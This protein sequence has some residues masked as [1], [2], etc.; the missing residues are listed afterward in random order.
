MRD[1]SPRVNSPS[2]RKPVISDE[3]FDSIWNL[4]RYSASLRSMMAWAIWLIP[5]CL[6][7]T[8]SAQ[9]EAP[10]GGIL[11]AFRRAIVQGSRPMGRAITPPGATLICTR[12]A[13]QVYTTNAYNNE[14]V[15]YLAIL[16][17][18]QNT[19]PDPITVF[20]KR[21]QLTVGMETFLRVQ[22]REELGSQPLLIDDAPIDVETLQ[23]QSE[24]VIPARS[25]A[26]VWLVYAKIPT[27]RE[28]PEVAIKIE[29]STGPIEVNLTQFENAAL[30]LQVERIGPQDC[31][32]IIRLTGELNALNASRF[33]AELSAVAEQGASRLVVAFQKGARLGDPRLSNWLVYGREQDSERFM[34]L[35]IWSGAIQDIAFVAIPGMAD[36][37]ED[38][39]A[40]SVDDGVLILSRRLVGQLDSQTLRQQLAA[41]HP[42]IRRAVL[43]SAGEMIAND[44][45]LLILPFLKAPDADARLAAIRALKSATA[46]AVI[47]PLE[48]TLLS[49]PSQEAFAALLS[50][51][52]SPI[53]TARS[54]AVA[55]IEDP[56]LQKKLGVMRILK[57]L[58]LSAQ[59][60]WHPWLRTLLTDKSANVR[61]Q[62]LQ[63]L[64]A[65]GVTDRAE[66]L[67]TALHDPQISVR[68]VAFDTLLVHRTDG[69]ESL[70][71][72]ETLRRSRQGTLD[73]RSRI[74]LRE[75]A[76]PG[77]LPIILK[78]IDQNPRENE[79]LVNLY[80]RIGGPAVSAEMI[81]RY[82]QFTP[83]TRSEILRQLYLGSDPAWIPLAIDGLEHEDD[84]H[85]ETCRNLLAEATDPTVLPKLAAAWKRSSDDRGQSICYTIG[86]IG[87]EAALQT[88]Q[89]MLKSAPVLRKKEIQLGITVW[90]GQS[91]S[92]EII[93]EAYSLSQSDKWEPAVELFT[94]AIE[95]GPNNPR[96]YSG[97]GHARLRL[98]QFDEAE[99]DFRRSMELDPDNHNSLSGLAICKAIRGQ[100]LDAIKMVHSNAML[101]QF[102]KEQIYLYNVACVYGRSLE[103]VLKEPASPQ[104]DARVH[105]FQ[106]Q[107]MRFLKSAVQ[108]GFDDG[109]LLAT[110]P[111]LNTLRELPAFQ[112]L[113]DRVP[114]TK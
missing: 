57:E 65:A 23:G 71:R 91:P 16:L 96:I 77:T 104:R 8:V 101:I 73:S 27:E 5:L 7:A 11:G 14:G 22:T 41:G 103:H 30:S 76:D 43:F 15:S 3:G 32:G 60:E 1:A 70:F 54:R 92:N 58:P 98:S 4:R 69:E 29:T 97:R 78:A 53:P 9:D 93:Q 113:R 107:A 112:K 45:H 82:N 17:R 74:A 48:E 79:D 36:E 59:P 38:N 108:Q 94:F 110:D 2:F 39:L 90:N 89:E 63:L 64:L 35:P 44:D 20:S 34:A 111:D 51:N 49:G 67:Q 6:S 55:L 87:T 106:E 10:T 26:W 47:S 46:P 28:L 68:N 37:S 109:H 95:L 24:Q 100:Y 12:D 13:I 61:G 52:G 75:L 84:D 62:T 66:L 86:S 72:E 85:A 40:S 88:L 21:C 19:G 31:I 83:D 50:L 105:Q 99:A 33:M 102:G 25:V 81:E 18:F 42:M 56:A 114:D 80:M